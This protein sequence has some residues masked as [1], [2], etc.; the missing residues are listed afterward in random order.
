MAIDPEKFQELANKRVGDMGA[1]FGAALVLVGDR[2]GLY[3]ALADKGPATS[4][5]LASRTATFERYI[6]E[7]LAAQ[8]SAGYVSMIH[9]RS[10]TS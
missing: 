6:R 9:R 2:L 5:E 8:A 7:W 1:A 10:V 4:E 3:K